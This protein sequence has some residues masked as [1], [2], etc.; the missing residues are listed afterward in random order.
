MTRT[1]DADV[2]VVGAGISGLTASR[3]LLKLGLTVVLLEARSRVG[4]RLASL[5]TGEGALDLGATWFWPNEPRIG[6]LVSELQLDTHAQY[7]AGDALVQDASGVHRIR[8]NPIDVKSRRVTLGLQAV[9]DSLAK[10]LPHE[11]I[12]YGSPVE[13]I[14]R[15]RDGV[16]ADT[17]TGRYVGQH[18]VIAIPPALAMSSIDFEPPLAEGT[19]RLARA[20]PVW[21]GGMTKVVAKYATPFWREAGLAGACMSHTG[22]MREVHDMSGADGSPAALFGFAPPL[23][24]GEP[25]VDREAILDQLQALFGSKAPEPVTLTIHDWRA[26]RFTSPPGVERLQAYELFGD[27]LYAKPE[28]DGH[29]HWASTETAPAFPGHIEGA[30]LAAARAVEAIARSGKDR[31]GASRNL[32]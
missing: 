8:G 4:G 5:D 28:M 31:S 14:L 30:L 16:S 19:A 17:A 11:T 21:M 18:L 24:P 9:A 22:P 27:P 6:A 10:E 20:T 32:I 1:D 12:R 15:T 25:T 2:L 29:V 26:E 23:A 3:E 13:R 7:L